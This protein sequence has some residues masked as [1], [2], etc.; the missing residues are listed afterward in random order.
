M[1]KNCAPR[2]GYPPGKKQVAL[3]LYT[4]RASVCVETSDSASIGP[5]SAVIQ[6][7]I[8]SSPH[9]NLVIITSQQN[10]LQQRTTLPHLKHATI[11]ST[12]YVVERRGT[13][14]GGPSSRRR[15]R[16][17]VHDAKQNSLRPG[18]DKRVN[19]RLLRA[20]ETVAGTLDLDPLAKRLVTIPYTNLLHRHPT[21]V[22][23]FY[24]YWAIRSTVNN[25]HCGFLFCP[26]CRSPLFLSQRAVGGGFGR[27]GRHG[28]GVFAPEKEVR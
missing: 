18:P 20:A 6:N 25:I 11:S 8:S 23:V 13:K 27:D 15:H 28:R 9:P 21:V 19:P 22:P 10:P 1:K 4:W 17:G 3:S 7:C 12:T 16:S 26:W 24:R 2:T 14:Y 5:T